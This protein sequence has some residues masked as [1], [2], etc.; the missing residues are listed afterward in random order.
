MK[1]DGKEMELQQIQKHLERVRSDKDKYSEGIIQLLNNLMEQSLEWKERAAK[2]RQL[3]DPGDVPEVGEDPS[4]EAVQWI[5][6]AFDTAA[7]EFS[8][9]ILDWYKQ[10]LSGVFSEEPDAFVV[11]PQDEPAHTPDDP[12]VMLFAP[13]SGQESDP[14]LLTGLLLG[15]SGQHY[16]EVKTRL[17]LAPGDI[18]ALKHRAE[19]HDLPL[20][21][22]PKLLAEHPPTSQEL[23]NWVKVSKPALR[24]AKRVARTFLTMMLS[25][26]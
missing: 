19:A 22:I 18:E 5:A 4:K 14:V 24:H 2:L 1:A 21:W 23:D 8:N 25:R 20:V 6:G 15:E 12:M 26:P 17:P 9:I 16:V 11:G 7:S 13:E 10:N 3:G